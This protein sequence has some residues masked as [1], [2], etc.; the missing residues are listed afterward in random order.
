MLCVCI[1]NSDLMSDMRC[2]GNNT[3]STLNTIEQNSCCKTICLAV[4]SCW[5]LCHPRLCLPIVL[6]SVSGRSWCVITTAI[7]PS[8]RSSKNCEPFLRFGFFDK[9]I[10][11]LIE[12]YPS[13]NIVYTMTEWKICRGG[14]AP[15]S[16]VI[17]TLFA[18]FKND[19]IY[20]GR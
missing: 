15:S 9:S 12:S 2:L 11:M 8:L 4:S 3:L 19:V 17:Y 5:H 14:D 7:E 18:A 10:W 20:I 6:A 1:S 16:V 13:L